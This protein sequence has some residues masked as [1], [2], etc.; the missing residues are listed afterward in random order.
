M[1]QQRLTFGA[2]RAVGVIPGLTAG[3]GEEVEGEEAMVL[4]EW[5][6]RLR[7]WIARMASELRMWPRRSG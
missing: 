6:E 1:V 2:G 5:E 3:S 7:A 4:A